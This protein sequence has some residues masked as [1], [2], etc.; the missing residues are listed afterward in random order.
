M[1]SKNGKDSTGYV[2]NRYREFIILNIEASQCNDLYVHFQGYGSASYYAVFD[3]HN[4][5]DAAIYSVSHLHQ[6]LAESPHYPDNP[7]LALKEACKSTNDLFTLKAERE[8]SSW[9]FVEPQLQS[10]SESW[11][12][13]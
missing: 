10:W 12:S 1:Y 8:V 4:G 7:M 13:V 5:I 3:G 9:L 2:I 11:L 6:Y